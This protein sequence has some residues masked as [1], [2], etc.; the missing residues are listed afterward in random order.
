M[1]RIQFRVLYREFLFRVVDLELLASQGDT[2]KLLG[3]FA[4]LMIFCSLWLSAIAAVAS[5]PNRHNPLL[6][7]LYAWMA[8][9]FLIAT[10]MLAVGL[11]AVMSW[12][13]T[14]PDRSDVLILSPLPV[15]ARTLLS[16]KVAAVA[17]ALSITVAALNLF[18]GLLLPWGF[19]S[20]GATHVIRAF[21]AWW[22]TQFA[23]G[24][25]VFCS[26]VTVQGLVQLL[27]RQVYLRVSSWLQAAFFILL[28]TV[29]FLQPPFSEVQDL[30]SNERALRWIPSYRFFGLFHQLNGAM[31]PQLA[32]LA[33]R[34]WT[35]LGAALC[36]AAAAYLIS[37]FRTLRMIAEQPDI[38][39]GRRGLHW[40]PRFGDSLQT[41]VA[42]FSVRTLLRSRH[43]RVLLMFYLGIGLGLAMFISHTPEV[44]L[45][46]SGFGEWY[47]LNGPL[48]MASCLIMCAAVLGTRV[49]F[50]LP[51]E[52]RA[53]WIFRM[54]P[55][56]GVTRCLAASRCSLYALAVAPIWLV[57]AALFFRLW[58]WRVAA[59]HLL[60][61]ATLGAIVAELCLHR[62]HK[63]PFT[64][65]YLPGKTQFNM[66]LVYLGLFLLV[67][68]WAAD[69][70][71]AALGSAALYGTTSCVLV[72][73]A[74]L[75]RWR[76]AAAARSEEGQV[77]FEE[78]PDPAVFALD[79]HRD[80]VTTIQ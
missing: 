25:F 12:E 26:V 50:S 39:P 40:L 56:A 52:M 57:S 22:A 54:M 1:T 28:L 31:L 58:P 18:T 73:V 16:A 62:F 27:P 71:M 55:R 67:T 38:V 35:G 7:M 6:G 48:L 5:G 2:N 79:L 23:A 66:A 37:Y 53:N 76:T 51:L 30:L 75:T 72:T 44:Y 36:G 21:G 68:E 64:C 43:H 19:A 70:E 61:L 77:Q 29:Y 4:G 47:R 20:G 13:T 60:L 11:F 9:H 65:S 74:L 46:A 45:R 17:T 15:R 3:Q 32:F 8:Q 41:A 69:R 63:I 24:L 59:E 78:V 42:Q 33:P 10:T 14:F 49:V 34:A 80:G